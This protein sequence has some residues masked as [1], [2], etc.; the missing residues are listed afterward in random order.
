MTKRVLLLSCILLSSIMVGKGISVKS[1]GYQLQG[2]DFEELKVSP[3]DLLVIDYSMDGTNESAWNSEDILSLK[4]HGKTVIAY[5]SIGE[6]EDF[7]YYWNDSWASSP[8]DWMDGE[9]PDWPGNYKVKYWTPEWQSIILDYLSVIVSQGFDGAYLD[10][11]DAYEYYEDQGIGDAAERMVDWVSVIADFARQIRP[12]FL[13]IPQNGEGL[14]DFEE[15]WSIIDG[16]G[17]EDLFFVDAG[18]PRDEASLNERLS[19]LNKLDGAKPVLVVD[20]VIS[21]DE[22][23][24]FY[25]LATSHGFIP[26]STVR[27]LDQLTIPIWLQSNSTSEDSLNFPFLGILLLIPLLQ[28]YKKK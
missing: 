15:Y 14:L 16:I 22:Q 23:M 9:N 17:I 4:E 2:I 7:R 12:D 19:H 26:Y 21:A 1:W 25:S 5:I 10:I 3:F 11:I 8:P 18:I 28:A 20:Y 24:E 6:A 13:L 27:D